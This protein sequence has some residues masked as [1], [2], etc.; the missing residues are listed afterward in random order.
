MNVFSPFEVSILLSYFP[1]AQ[2]ANTITTLGWV[3]IVLGI[4]LM[5]LLTWWIIKSAK[6]TAPESKPTVQVP[7]SSIEVPVITAPL[8]LA[9]LS[10]TVGPEEPTRITGARTAELDTKSIPDNLTI[11]EGIG[12][13]ISG[14]LQAAGI[15]TFSQLADLEPAQ[16][17]KI[18]TQGGIRLGD[19]TTWP[20]QARLAAGGDLA[21]LKEFQDRLI[22]GRSA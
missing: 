22:A 17:K 20:D 11:I 2:K 18:L 12:P 4:I 19:P 14:I 10:E 16:I 15:A 6:Q 21:A 8:A 9:P 3:L 5:F 13:K 7:E 1:S